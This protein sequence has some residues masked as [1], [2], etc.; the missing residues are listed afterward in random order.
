MVRST[1]LIAALTI[2]SALAVPGVTRAAQ[3]DATRVLVIPFTTLNVADDQ[4][5]IGRAIEENIIAD[6]G[7]SNAYMPVAFQGQ[8]LVEDNATAITLAHKANADL[9][10]R[11]A[12][13]RVDK[14]LRI[15]AQMIDARTGDSLTTASVTG[16]AADLLKLEDDLSA[17]LR[18]NA[19]SAQQAQLQAQPQQ[20]MAAPQ[21]ADSAGGITYTPN[22]TYATPSYTPGYSY[23]P[24]YVAPTYYDYGYSPA[25]YGSYPYYSTYGYGYPSFYF[26]SSYGFGGYY[27]HG[28][29]G[30]GRGFDHD[31]DDFR[32]G[33]D[34][35][36]SGGGFGGGRDSFGGGDTTGGFHG[37]GSG[38]I[39]VPRGATGGIGAGGGGFHSGSGGF[40]GGMSAGGTHGG[41][42]SGHR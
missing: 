15:T 29:Y 34:G 20:Q 6:F 28:Y 3:A 12:A 38:G 18:T 16:S 23:D 1:S 30:R 25:Y 2:A 19:A 35:G 9:V 13:Q 22:P 11:G 31:G 37:G 39:V 41:G 10:I 24:T 26:G 32:G 27:N 8:L 33:R 36:R 14:T 5:W 21:Q 17:Q 7:H 40:T 42:T 4:Q